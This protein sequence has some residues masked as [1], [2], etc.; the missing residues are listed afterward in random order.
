MEEEIEDDVMFSLK[1]D[2][3]E[4]FDK[5]DLKD[6]TRDGMIDCEFLRKFLDNESELQEKLA[7]NRSQI[8]KL[9]SEAD[10]NKDEFLDKEE[11]L[12]LAMKR[13]E[14]QQSKSVFRQ[15]LEKLAYAEEFKCCPP[16]LFIIIITVLQI[17]FFAM[18]KYHYPVLEPKC[19]YLILRCVYF[20]VYFITLK[21]ELLHYKQH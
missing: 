21:S 15:Y 6:G 18:N 14:S 8:E 20:S 11:F 2:L 1:N 10:L 9:I 19:S 7:M 16:P 3:L 4:I 13:F 17:F 5:L 12:S